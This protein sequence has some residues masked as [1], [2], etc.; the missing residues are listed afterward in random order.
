MSVTEL[1]D[2]P[3]APAVGEALSRDM[4][5]DE[6]TNAKEALPLPEGTKVYICY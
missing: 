2:M 6:L 5:A 4:P 1:P 3:E